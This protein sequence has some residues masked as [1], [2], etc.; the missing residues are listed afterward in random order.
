MRGQLPGDNDNSEIVVFGSRI[1]PPD[2]SCAPLFEKERR[3]LF[4]GELFLL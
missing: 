3:N 2:Y 1:L 4:S